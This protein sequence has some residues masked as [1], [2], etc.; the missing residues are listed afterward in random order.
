MIQDNGIPDLVLKEDFL[1][2]TLTADNGFTIVGAPTISGNLYSGITATDYIYIPRDLIT[3]SQKLFSFNMRVYIPSTSTDFERIV[4]WG[5][6]W[7]VYIY[8]TLDRL[9]LRRM[10]N[11]SSKFAFIDFTGYYDQWVD[12][13]FSSYELTSCLLLRLR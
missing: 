1:N 9:Y 11:G 13:S 7:R 3:L 12:V 10:V 8:P 5:S 4:S 6:D 2:P